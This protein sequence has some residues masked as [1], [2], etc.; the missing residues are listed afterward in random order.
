MK[1]FREPQCHRYELPDG[2]IALA[3]KSDADNELLSLHTARPRDWWFHVNGMPGSHVILQHPEKKEPSKVL[4][5][6]VAAIA[7][8]HSKARD[9]GL[10]SVHCARA[11]DVGKVPGSKTGTVTLKKQ[12]VLKVRPALPT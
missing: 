4:L 6:T 11:V 3:G 5:K 2:W 10:V 1:T 8:W 12:T 7:A 9:A